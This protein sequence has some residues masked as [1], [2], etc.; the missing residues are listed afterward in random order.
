MPIEKENKINDD[1]SF[2]FEQVHDFKNVYVMLF[3]SKDVVDNQITLELIDHRLKQ[4]FTR[5]FDVFYIEDFKSYCFKENNIYEVSNL[6]K[7]TQKEYEDSHYII[8]ED[9]TTNDKIQD[10]DK[11]NLILNI[12][13]IL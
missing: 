9:K 12:L 11:Q 10:T 8:T 6:P 2:V 5:T 3:N 4:T 7:V 1:V 13:K